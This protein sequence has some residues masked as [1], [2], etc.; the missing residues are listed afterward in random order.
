[1]EHFKSLSVEEEK[2]F[3]EACEFAIQQT[4][5]IQALFA[6]DKGDLG[7]NA[8]DGITGYNNST[9]DR[10]P[11]MSAFKAGKREVSVI[12]RDMI[13]RNVKEAKAEMERK[14]AKT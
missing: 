11:Y 8:I 6:G 3:R 1:M 9:F 13:N 4:T 12:L 2:E 14:D 7:L 5:D 10:D